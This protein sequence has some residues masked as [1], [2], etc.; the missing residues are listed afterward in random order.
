V[1]TSPCSCVPCDWCHGSGH[2]WQCLNG[3]IVRDR[4]DDMGDLIPCPDYDGSGVS[5]VCENCMYFDPDEL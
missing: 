2:V 1:S 4:C 5:E 3:D